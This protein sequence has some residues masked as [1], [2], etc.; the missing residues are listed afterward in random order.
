MIN[1]KL[2]IS[3]SPHIL[4]II[5]H[6][7][8]PSHSFSMSKCINKNFNY[9][10]NLFNF[11]KMVT[12]PKFLET[13]MASMARFGLKCPTLRRIQIT[14]SAFSPKLLEDAA[15]YLPH[16]E[17]AIGYG[18]SEVGMISGGVATVE[19]FK[20]GYVGK[21]F[22]RYDAD[23]G[24]WQQYWVDGQGVVLRLEGGLVDGNMVLAGESVQKGETVLNRI[25]WTPNDDG[26]VRQHWES[27][28]D[29]GDTW[30][31]LFDGLYKRAAK[32]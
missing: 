31:T 22:N 21:S 30:G 16:A 6:F 27:S 29:G 11:T 18:T 2:F 5:F 20:S 15:R 3:T 25:R 1:F 26:T 24:K 13:A 9:F 12:T 17:L 19:K 23:T 4:T 32:D 10:I 8:C 14:G 28:K 7:D